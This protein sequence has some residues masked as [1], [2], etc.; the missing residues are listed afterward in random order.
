MGDLRELSIRNL[1]IGCIS[2]QLKKVTP[3]EDWIIER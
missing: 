2:N 1:R 3:Y